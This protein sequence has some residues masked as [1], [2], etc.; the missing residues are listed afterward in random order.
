MIAPLATLAFF[1]VTPVF[2]TRAARLLGS[3]RAN[4]GRL[5]VA[6]VAL[7]AWA[8]LFGQGLEG[9]ALPWFVAG[10]VIGFGVG[11]IAMFQSLPRIGSTLS[12][13][14]VQCLSAVTAVVVEWMWLGTTLTPLQLTCAAT[15][16]AGVVLGLA[17]RSLARPNPAEWRAGVAWAILSAL[18]QGVGAVISRKAFLVT[19]LARDPIDPGT[20]TYQRVL[21][22][23][24]I[25]G[26][27]LV[28]CRKDATRAAPRDLFR[29][30]TKT[31]LPPD[32]AGGTPALPG[33]WTRAWWWVAAN[34]ATGPILGVT[35]YQ[36][37][38]RSTPA[39]IVQPIV[40]A[41][42]LLTIPLAAWLEGTR[43]RGTYYIGAVLAVAGVSGLMV[44]R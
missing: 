33:A 15:T 11:G 32:I 39:G 43:P 20:A 30:E 4:F 9:A 17:P 21:G 3:L 38:L 10:G 18:G 13:L 8:H 22:G 29:N 31:G 44:S 6:L 12:T 41:A 19:A 14:I 5:L 16:L 2:A 7:G 27:V 34:A 42:P 28:F 37:A 24:F 23:I 25:A 40:A 36:W 35:C 26:L 1:A